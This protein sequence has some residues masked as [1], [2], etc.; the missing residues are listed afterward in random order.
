[1]SCNTSRAPG[2]AFFVGMVVFRSISL[3]ITPPETQRRLERHVGTRQVSQT[4]RMGLAYIYTYNI[5]PLF[6]HPNVGRYA[7]R[8][9]SGMDVGAH[10]QRSSERF[11]KH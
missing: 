5:Q 9:W 2:F 1:M 11:R 4:I 10:H 3:V 6:N 7:I 8:G